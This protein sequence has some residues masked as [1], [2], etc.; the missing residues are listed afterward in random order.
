[1]KQFVVDSLNMNDISS[2]RT[3]LIKRFGQPFMD[4]VFWIELEDSI[5]SDEQKK[6]KDCAPH[7]FALSLKETSLV[8][9][10]LVRSR[11]KMRCSC[12]GYAG[13]GQILWLVGLIDDILIEANVII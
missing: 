7:C 8:A 10:T 5:L 12:M 4:E 13:S 3:V 11:K 6:H 1:M 2:L 9:E